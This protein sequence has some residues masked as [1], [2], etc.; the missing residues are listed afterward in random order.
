MYSELTRCRSAGG[1]LRMLAEMPAQM[2]RSSARLALADRLGIDHDLDAT[3]ALLA[4]RSGIRRDRI[5][6]AMS[7]DK[8]LLRG[9]LVPARELFKH[10][11][12]LGR[13][14][15]M[16]IPP[17]GALRRSVIGVRFD[18]DRLLRVVSAESCWR[19]DR[20]AHA[21]F[22][23]RCR[24]GAKMRSDGSSMRITSPSGRTSN[25]AILTGVRLRRRLLLAV[26]VA[27]PRRCIEAFSA[28]TR[29]SGI[30]LYFRDLLLRVGLRL[31]NA[32]LGLLLSLQS[33]VELLRGVGQ[34]LLQ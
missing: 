5:V 11:H 31:Q 10:R 9:E 19:P 30:T 1:R 29:C 17:S 24:P 25:P 15:L 32:L 28:E 14:Q 21:R 16:R 6:R 33:S 27:L 8:Q 23:Q 26:I 7:Q 18:T 3:V 34:L 4:G 20:S 13:R 2:G 12:R 22:L